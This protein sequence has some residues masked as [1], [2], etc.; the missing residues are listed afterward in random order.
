MRL[1]RLHQLVSHFMRLEAEATELDLPNVRAG[2]EAARQSTIEE[3]RRLEPPID[4]GESCHSS[5]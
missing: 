5:T 4:T 2:L 1:A 3:L